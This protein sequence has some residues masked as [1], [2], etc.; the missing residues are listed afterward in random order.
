M[1]LPKRKKIRLENYDYSSGNVYFVTVC[2]KNRSVVLW[3]IEEYYKMVGADCKFVGADIIRLQEQ[4]A[5][6]NIPEM[7][8]QIANT[9]VGAVIN[10]PKQQMA[11]INPSEEQNNVRAEEDRRIVEENGWI[12]EKNGRIIS[13]PTDS[14]RPYDVLLSD[15]GEVVKIAIENI[16]IHYENVDVLNYC[17]M[18]NHVHMIIRILPTDVGSV[19]N[20]GAV[21]NRPQERL[22]NINIPETYGQIANVGVGADIIRPK[23]Q[24]AEIGVLQ[25][26]SVNDSGQIADEN[27]RMTEYSRR[28]AEDNGRMVSAP[29][30]STVVGSMKRWVSKQIGFHL[31]QK[32]FHA[33]II[34]D[35]QEL[36]EIWRYIDDNPLN[37]QYDE[38]YAPFYDDQA[39]KEAQP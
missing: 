7:D 23:Q 2:V 11:G 39:L 37:W 16:P 1:D 32:S 22:A 3:D 19:V 17:I 8:G 15:F 13:A 12:A 20:V 34:R 14:G 10:R 33:H 35:E 5:N 26:R 4:S 18:P 21:I 6:I 30:L 29:T 9:G 24:S 25:E 38:D 31:W 27:S 28:I 36:K